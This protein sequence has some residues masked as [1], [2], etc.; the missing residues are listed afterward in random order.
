MPGLAA[1][2]LLFLVSAGG[3]EC[4]GGPG[5]VPGAGH[6]DY[7]LGNAVR[8]H[9]LR[10]LLLSTPSAGTART[11]G[12]RITGFTP[13]VA[14]D[15]CTIPIRTTGF[16][17]M[18]FLPASTGTGTSTTRGWAG[19]SGRTTTKLL[20]SV[21]FMELGVVRPAHT[22][23]PPSCVTERGANE[24]I[25]VPSSTA[26]PLPEP[27]IVSGSNNGHITSRVVSHSEEVLIGDLSH[28]P[29]T[30]GDSGAVP[31]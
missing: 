11:P 7:S 17:I 16:T 5:P 13:T 30:P 8:E 19:A 12:T 2:F 26:V 25:P 22:P 27:T 6:T 28:L 15:S 9:P 14:P 10:L 18:K 4:V 1:V 21:V 3:R 24:A 31:R 29:L 23:E 20:I